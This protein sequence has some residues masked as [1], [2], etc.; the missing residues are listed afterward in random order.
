MDPYDV[1]RQHRIASHRLDK[2]CCARDDQKRGSAI[3]VDHYGSPAR[4]RGIVH[5]RPGV[6]YILVPYSSTLSCL[7]RSDGSDGRFPRETR[8]CGQ[9]RI[10][11]ENP[12]KP[13]T[14]PWAVFDFVLA[15][16][17]KGARQGKVVSGRC[18]GATGRLV[19]GP[20]ALRDPNPGGLAIYYRRVAHR[21]C[22]CPEYRCPTRCPTQVAGDEQ[23][24]LV[25]SA[26]YPYSRPL[27]MQKSPGRA[28]GHRPLN[29][30]QARRQHRK[31][32]NLSR[33]PSTTGV[34]LF[35]A[36]RRTGPPRGVGQRLPADPGQGLVVG[37]RVDA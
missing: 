15:A 11:S 3:P 22:V 12:S 28:S 6:T 7:F 5:Y 20:S 36:H 25:R 9:S 32:K 17:G 14:G 18:P 1:L 19:P 23:R 37:G 8:R 16:G 2:S 21:P 29:P 10:Q 4:S 27:Q 33:S 26:M 13:G 30:R 24:H 31:K 35:E 34:M